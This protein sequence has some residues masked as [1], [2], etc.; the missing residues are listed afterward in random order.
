VG[1]LRPSFKLTAT[2]VEVEISE[3]ALA[4]PIL[5]VGLRDVADLESAKRW[6]HFV[7]EAESEL[8]SPFGQVQTFRVLVLIDIPYLCRYALDLSGDNLR[9]TLEGNYQDP[10]QENDRKRGAEP[11]LVLLLVV[12]SQR[13]RR[14]KDVKFYEPV[15]SFILFNAY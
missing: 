6:V 1:V 9:Q 3:N 13:D 2:L 12:M 11:R 10:K 14:P 7:F 5:V 4:I 8:E 15:H